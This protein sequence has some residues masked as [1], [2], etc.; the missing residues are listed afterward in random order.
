M[1]KAGCLLKLRRKSARLV[2][3]DIVLPIEKNTENKAYGSHMC[4]KGTEMKPKSSVISPTSQ[5]GN[6]LVQGYKFSFT[7]ICVMGIKA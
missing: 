4:V 7:T 1:I 3:I 2:F 6:Q 5:E